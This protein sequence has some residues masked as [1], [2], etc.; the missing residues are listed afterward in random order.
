MHVAFTCDIC[1]KPAAQTYDAR[2]PLSPLQLLCNKVEARVW[3]CVN[4]FGDACVCVSV[5]LTCVGVCCSLRKCLL[6][7]VCVRVGAALSCPPDRAAGRESCTVSSQCCPCKTFKFRR[8]GFKRSIKTLLNCVLFNLF[9]MFWNLPLSLFQSAEFFD[10]L[11]RMQV[12]NSQTFYF[13]FS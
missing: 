1:T 6:I 12:W 5:V 2:G 11:E 10:M 13:T 9:C 3:E 8:L 4:A 7:S